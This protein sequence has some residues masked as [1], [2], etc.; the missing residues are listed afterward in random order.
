MYFLNGDRIYI[1]PV[2]VCGTFNDE[3]Q[4]CLSQLK[5]INSGKK[6]FNL[7]FFIEAN[8]KEEY[9]HFQQ[10]IQKEIYNQFSSEILISVLA[11]PPLT[12]KLIIEA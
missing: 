11:Q 1:K 12:G 8:S 9:I 6:I 2:K 10:N 7:N 5:N 4:N 3:L